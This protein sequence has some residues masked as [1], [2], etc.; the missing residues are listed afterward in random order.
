M[1]TL[2]VMPQQDLRVTKTPV[3]LSDTPVKQDIQSH[4]AIAPNLPSM[5]FDSVSC[6]WPGNLLG[7]SGTLEHFFGCSGTLG[8]KFWGGMKES[9]PQAPA[10]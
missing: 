6:D 8:I 4:W 10:R 2:L 1:R 7:G 5:Q 3:R 9:G